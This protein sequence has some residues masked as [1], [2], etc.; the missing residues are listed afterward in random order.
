[1]NVAVS[2]PTSPHGVRL[3]ARDFLLL[4]DNGAFDKYSKSELIDGEIVCVNS[5]LRPHAMA[6]TNLAYQ[7]INALQAMDSSLTVIVEVGVKLDDSNLFEPDIVVVSDS[8]D[9]VVPGET[10]VLAVEVS[11][12]TLRHDLVR[13]AAFYAATGIPEYW[14]LD[15]NKRVLHQLW[16][17]GPEGFGERREIKLGSVVEAVTIAGLKIETDRV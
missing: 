12:T 17:P 3:S 6:K 8:E 4:V 13:K 11:D 5:Q 2:D 14:V 15:V 9:R 1:M 7:L 10:V 16:A